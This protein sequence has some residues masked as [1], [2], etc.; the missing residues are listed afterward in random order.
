[1]LSNHYKFTGS[2]LAKAILD[3]F[4]KESRWFVKVMPRDYRRVLEHKAEIEAK[5]AALGQRQA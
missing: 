4:E 2:T 3:D 1:L 5:A